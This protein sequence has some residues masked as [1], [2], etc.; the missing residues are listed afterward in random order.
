MI[1]V[2]LADL[3]IRAFEPIAFGSAQSD[4]GSE[5]FLGEIKSIRISDQAR[6]YRGGQMFT[7]P[8]VQADELLPGA[9]LTLSNVKEM[10]PEPKPPMISIDPPLVESPTKSDPVAPPVGESLKASQAAVASVFGERMSMAMKPEGKG[11]TRGR[12]AKN[13]DERPR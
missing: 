3:R 11:Q 5:P 10:T 9:S 12:T 8:A 1:G 13:G 4:Q 7:P 6:L 2:S